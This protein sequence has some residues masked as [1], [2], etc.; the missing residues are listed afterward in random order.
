[1][2]SHCGE[3]WGAGIPSFE[4]GRLMTLDCAWHHRLAT[5]SKWPGSQLLVIVF[6]LLSVV[7]TPQYGTAVESPLR[8]MTY[9]VAGTFVPDH[10]P[11]AVMSPQHPD[12]VLLQEVRNTR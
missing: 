6:C 12:L 11:L 9:N 10:A 5:G 7:V 8:V 1:M 4:R 3:S 2:P